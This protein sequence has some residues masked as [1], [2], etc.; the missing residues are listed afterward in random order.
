MLNKLISFFLEK[1]NSLPP[2][3]LPAAV[4]PQLGPDATA[5]GQ[6][7]WYTLEGLDEKGNPVGGWDLHELRSIQD[8]YVR[9]ALNSVQGV[10]EVASVGGT[11]EGIPG[12]PRP[13]CHEGL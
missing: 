5:L 8:Y 13:R 11:C 9:L 6:V 1:H 7:F 2:G 3:L 4:T 10:S 12:G